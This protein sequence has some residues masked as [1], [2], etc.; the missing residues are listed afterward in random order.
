MRFTVK[1]LII[2][3]TM[4]CQLTANDFLNRFI[5]IENHITSND[6]G[7]GINGVANDDLI[8]IFDTVGGINIDT[9]RLNTII[10]NLD[11]LDL[12]Q[13]ALSQT[14]SPASIVDIRAI[15]PDLN[16]AEADTLLVL[17]QQIQQIQLLKVILQ[18]Q[19]QK[20]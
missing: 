9:P 17:L 6:L 19:Q 15:F 13:N 3:F 11:N 10:Y 1:Y 7:S 18:V 8:M 16:Q 14:G 4:S 5:L 12:Y 20:I 2:L